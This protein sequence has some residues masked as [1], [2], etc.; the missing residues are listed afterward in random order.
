MSDPI[1]ARLHADSPKGL[2]GRKIKLG[3][4]YFT[5]RTAPSLKSDTGESLLGAHKHTSQELWINSDVKPS[6]FSAVLIH[7]IMHEM[8]IQTG[9]VSDEGIAD[10][11]AYFLAQVFADNPW[12]G[13]T[14]T[15]QEGEQDDATMVSERSYRA[16]QAR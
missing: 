12:L 15:V 10:A 16:D 2:D 14:L 3:Q 9:R 13:I 8:F 6:L 7:E 1:R 5:I 11:V 4:F